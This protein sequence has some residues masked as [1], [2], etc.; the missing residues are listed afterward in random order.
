MKQEY[1]K[2]FKGTP[3]SIS[4][5][6]VTNGP[7]QWN[8]TKFSI[9]NKDLLIGQYIYNYEDKTAK[10]FYPFIANGEWYALYSA[11]YTATR[12]MKLHDDRIEDWCGDNPSGNG[13][14]PV[15]FYV[16][17]YRLGS[18]A[19]IDGSEV[20]FCVHENE[21]EFDTHSTVD[22]DGDKLGPVEYCK[23]GFVSGCMWGDDTCWKI[24][25]IDLSKV[26]DKELII[27]EKFG[28]AMQPNNMN[29]KQCI[30]MDDWEPNHPVIQLA[31]FQFFNLGEDVK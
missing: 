21:E 31:T 9:Y 17:R 24:R 30:C 19:N 26:A 27:T 4:C 2:L 18:F 1:I 25:Y 10:T 23:F 12:V 22:S 5:E 6:N 14:C 29:L 28:Y 3:F 11:H 13:F 15:E 20:S 16:P 8:S 7:N